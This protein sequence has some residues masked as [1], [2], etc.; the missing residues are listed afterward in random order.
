MSVETSNQNLNLVNSGGGA[1]TV[2]I[3]SNVGR[4]NG[5]TSLPCK[6][7]WIQARIAN[8]GTIQVNINIAATAAL[9]ITL[10]HSV[11]GVGVSNEWLKLPIDDVSK[12]YFYGATNGDDIDILYVK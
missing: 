4:G 3:A 11:S 6:L 9:G 5:G 10:P 12:L 2:A 7:C 1:V 8:S